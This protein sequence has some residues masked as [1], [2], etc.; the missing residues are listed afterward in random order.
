MSFDFS[1]KTIL[2]VDDMTPMLNLTRNLLGVMGFQHIYT[3]SN[4]REA[5]ELFKEYSPDI[6]LTDLIMKYCDG[7]ELASLVR[8]HPDSPNPMVPILLM[9]GMSSKLSAEKARDMGITEFLV[10]PFASRDLYR[11]IQYA[12]ENPRDFIRGGEYFGPDRRRKSITGFGKPKRKDDFSTAQ[13]S[14]STDSDA[15]QAILGRLHNEAHTV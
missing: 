13:H 3:A 11:R 6:I 14:Q 5:F 8:K 4:G 10:K 1:N 9:T 2:L 12:F 7:I 15:I